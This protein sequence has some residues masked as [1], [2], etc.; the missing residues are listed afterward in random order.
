MKCPERQ[1][2]DVKVILCKLTPNGKSVAVLNFQ[3]RVKTSISPD[4]VNH[5]LL[6]FKIK[7]FEIC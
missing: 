2:K 7:M 3:A 5:L 4:L 6:I 1:S